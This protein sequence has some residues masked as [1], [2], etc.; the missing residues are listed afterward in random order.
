[1]NYKKKKFKKNPTATAR[2]L[3]LLLHRRWRMH[4]VLIGGARCRV[5]V[6]SIVFVCSGAGSLDGI[7][8]CSGN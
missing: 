1:M 7:G 4:V 8:G 6:A 2:H 5:V 3:L